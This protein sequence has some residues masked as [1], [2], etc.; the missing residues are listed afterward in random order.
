MSVRVRPAVPAD[1]GRL[2]ELASAVASEP[3]G[4][5]LADSRWRSESDERRYIRALQRHPDAALL[6]AELESGEL[7]GRLSL[8]RDPHPASA[9]VADLGVMVAL[10]HRRSGI[11]TALMAAAEDWAR[12]AHVR[13]L[14]L[15]VFPYNEAAIRL[16]EKLGYEREGLRRHHYARAEGGYSDV[17]LMAKQLVGSG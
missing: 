9:H 15:H 4:W 12:S 2:V 14:E 17:V 13:K 11:G 3:E 5:L 8:M 16:Y 6:V 10:G 7:V 1:A